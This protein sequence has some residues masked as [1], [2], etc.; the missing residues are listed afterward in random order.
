MAIEDA[1]V[2][3]LVLDEHRPIEDTLR[4]FMDRR[5]ARARYIQD[6]SLMISRAEMEND[7]TLNH[8]AV[9]GAMLHY[10]AQPI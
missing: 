6:Q 3:S 4:A 8:P 7:H 10:T 5:F 2:L 9:I 1:V